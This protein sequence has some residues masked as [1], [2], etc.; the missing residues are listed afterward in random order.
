MK[1]ELSDHMY[2]CKECNLLNIINTEYVC[3]IQQGLGL[4]YF[5][6]PARG[7]FMSSP[8]GSHT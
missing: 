2:S 4:T 5:C 6:T 1:N 8:P 7:A 3:N